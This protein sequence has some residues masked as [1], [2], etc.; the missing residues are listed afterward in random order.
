MLGAVRPSGGGVNSVH[1]RTGAVVAA[2]SDYSATQIVGLGGGAGRV[3]FTAG[4]TQTLTATSSISSSF[5]TI[6]ITA[7]S[8]IT[9]T[10]NP[11]ITAGNNNQKL[12]IINLGSNPITL[13]NGNGMLLPSNLIITQGRVVTLHYSTSFNAWILEG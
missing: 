4:G 13:V 3:V 7:A 10:S 8:A 12:T 1:G 5:G 2:T 9:L 6:P 11:Q